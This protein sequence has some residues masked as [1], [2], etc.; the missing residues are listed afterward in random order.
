MT[1]SPETDFFNQIQL[2]NRSNLS[3]SQ[4]MGIIFGQFM[5]S[6]ATEHDSSPWETQQENS[7]FDLLPHQTVVSYSLTFDNNLLHPAVVHVRLS[8]W[9]GVGTGFLVLFDA[10]TLLALRRDFGTKIGQRAFHALVEPKID[11]HRFL[12]GLFVI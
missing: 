10:T 9:H 3:Q 1:R 12:S 4:V 2:T 8:R 7:C 6:T 5:E 11:M